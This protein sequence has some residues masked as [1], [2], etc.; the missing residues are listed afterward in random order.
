MDVNRARESLLKERAEV[1][2]LLKGE[3]TS[4][5]EDREAEADGATGDMADV[6]QPLTQEYEDDS[7]TDQLT[8]RL[9]AID[10]ALQRIKDGTYGL[11]VK[12]GQP[13][14]DERLEADPAAE[15]TIEEARA[16]R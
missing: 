16:A 8:G 10:R 15:L 9:D 1:E 13:I 11:S 3:Q 2:G 4:G 12:S 5:A 14:P 6:A 7:I